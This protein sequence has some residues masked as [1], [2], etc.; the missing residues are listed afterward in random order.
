MSQ[1]AAGTTAAQAPVVIDPPRIPKAMRNAT[2]DINSFYDENGQL[3]D[4][5]AAPPPP[6]VTPQSNEPLAP[7]APPP[8]PDQTQL[9]LPGVEPAPPAPP[10]PPEDMAAL[11]HKWRSAE[12][13]LLSA[14]R[15]IVALEGDLERAIGQITML[16]ARVTQQPAPYQPGP[17]A[18]LTPEE[19]AALGPEMVSMLNRR[20]EVI[21]RTAMAP[22]QAQIQALTN[23]QQARATMTAAQAKENLYAELGAE[24]PN[25]ATINNDPAFM[26]W[27]LQEEGLSGVSRQ[28]LLTRAF[29]ANNAQR[30]IAF[31]KTFG[32]DGGVPNTR[33]GTPH[34]QA[35]PNAPQKV[36]LEAF[37]APAR[38]SSATPPLQQ[39]AKN[40][41]T[42][43]NI[44][45]FY[46]DVRKGKF[47]GREAE[48]AQ[49]E[50]DLM[51]A[52]A[53]GRVQS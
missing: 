12:G 23:S 26:N 47:V 42:A 4:P 8:A 15:R 14:N 27:L 45:A 49:W 3:R 30:V 53:E 1:F 32:N 34:T 33:A 10:A 6:P 17:M 24:V 38:G 5:S 36:P 13:R 40:I 16:E 43:A 31:F 51:L 28:T 41:W 52:Q 50:A 25:W 9:E 29:E 19:E 21:A 35:A 7:P 20:A 48:K 2:A 46:A 39:P 37:A 18:D 44:S 22:L 11:E